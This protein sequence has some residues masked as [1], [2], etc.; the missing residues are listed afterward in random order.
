MNVWFVN[1]SFLKPS[2]TFR[3]KASKSED[4]WLPSVEFNANGSTMVSVAALTIFADCYPCKR[5]LT[6]WERWVVEV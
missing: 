5:V 4:T 1:V 2:A 3:S 6:L